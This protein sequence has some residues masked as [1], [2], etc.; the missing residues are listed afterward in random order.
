MEAHVGN[1]CSAVAQNETKHVA[2]GL[3][4]FVVELALGIRGRLHTRARSALLPCVAQAPA[5]VLREVLQRIMDATR[6]GDDIEPLWGLCVDLPPA[7]PRGR[8]LAALACVVRWRRGRLLTPRLRDGSTD[9]AALPH[10]LALS[11]SN[12]PVSYTHLR[13]HET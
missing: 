3:A 2:S 9:D 5:D 11:R 6:P 1:V 10:S 13:A 12:Q 8:A 4:H 7:V